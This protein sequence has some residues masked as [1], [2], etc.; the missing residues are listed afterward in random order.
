MP[1]PDSRIARTGRHPVLGLAV[2][3]RQVARDQVRRELRDLEKLAQVNLHA[4]QLGHRRY[5]TVDDAAKTLGL[6]AEKTRVAHH[7]IG[8]VVKDTRKL[9]GI[10]KAAREAGIPREM[11]SELIRRGVSIHHDR[12]LENLLVKAKREREED[13]DKQDKPDEKDAKSRRDYANVP[14]DQDKDTTSDRDPNRKEESQESDGD[15]GKKIPRS[16]DR[17][18]GDDHGVNTPGDDDA[19]GKPDAG[20]EDIDLEGDGQADVTV[21]DADQQVG[22]AP[23]KGEPHPEVKSRFE[24]ICEQAE[25]YGQ[26]V[27]ARGQGLHEDHT[28]D[29][30]DALEHKIAERI[31]EK[32]PGAM[33]HEAKLE[34][35]ALMDAPE[36]AP[37][38]GVGPG[39]IAEPAD[40]NAPAPGAPPGMESEG[41]P[42]P[43]QEGAEDQQTDHGTKQLQQKVHEL[44]ASLAG[45]EPRLDSD[46]QKSMF[47]ELQSDIK[48]V[49]SKPDRSAVNWLEQRISS[50]VKMVSGAGEEK[51][52]QQGEQP[53]KKVPPQFQK[54]QLLFDPKTGALLLSK[55]MP[56]KYIRRTTKSGGG[57][58]Y[59]YTDEDANGHPRKKQEEPPAPSK[60]GPSLGLPVGGRGRE[61]K[62]SKPGLDNLLKNGNYSVVS[63]G[64]NP[65]H[66]AE[67]KMKDTDPSFAERH[68]RLKQDIIGAGFNYT[69]VTGHY[70]GDEISLVVYHAADPVTVGVARGGQPSF[71]VH[72]REGAPK[73]DYGKI[74]DLGKKYNQDSVIHSRKGAHEL[75]YTTGK[76]AGQ[77]VKGAGHEYKAGAED[78]FTAVKTK[79]GQSKFSLNFDWG[80]THDMG[81]AIL[82]S[83]RRKVPPPPPRRRKIIPAIEPKAHGPHPKNKYGHRD[84]LEPGMI[85][86]TRERHGSV[87]VTVLDGGRFKVSDE[88]YKGNHDLLTALYGKR[89]HRMTARRYFKLGGERQAKADA[90]GMLRKALQPHQVLVQRVENGYALTGDLQK[91]GIPDYMIDE[92]AMHAVL[93]YDAAIDL[94]RQLGGRNA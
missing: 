11:I 70:G 91:A 92:S 87:D 10:S 9:I 39:D 88:I 72:H 25:K 82:K 27:R 16:D 48:S 54:A 58:R 89:D 94:Y 20:D 33:R 71:I 24:E 31:R 61:I 78:L 2:G 40:P 83:K 19:D 59:Y 3:H 4:S 41:P 57:Y 37:G 45:I 80:K 73:T 62:L 30:L 75:H 29:H 15:Q 21:G 22:D 81:S 52:Q 68:E 50:F 53:G 28:H 63:A 46:H 26:S 56:H 1:R 38:E 42:V 67:A 64:R 55:A 49:M 7:L 6:N 32:F 86:K 79:G 5:V 74:R 18:D 47:K 36:G 17:K 60:K 76:Q 14:P 77:H 23:P 8:E 93:D 34:G 66:S 69:E 65:A 35:Q 90:F 43:G 51:D 12:R 44:Q 85:L 84:N 13:D